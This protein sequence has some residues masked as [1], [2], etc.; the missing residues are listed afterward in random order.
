MTDHAWITRPPTPQERL[1]AR[2]KEAMTAA[3]RKGLDEG[4]VAVLGERR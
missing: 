4:R 2:R 3:L 1:Y